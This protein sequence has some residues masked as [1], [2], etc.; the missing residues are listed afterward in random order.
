MPGARERARGTSLTA[1]ARP[2]QNVSLIV[3]LSYAFGSGSALMHDS[4]TVVPTP[5]G[6]VVQSEEL[7]ILVPCQS[8]ISTN[9]ESLSSRLL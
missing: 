9:A 6:S 4:D 7:I 1:S 2:A 5:M 3:I 8:L